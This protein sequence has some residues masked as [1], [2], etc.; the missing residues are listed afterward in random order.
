M[1]QENKVATIFGIIFFSPYVVFAYRCNKYFL[2]KEPLTGGRL[3][4]RQFGWSFLTAIPLVGLIYG[5]VKLDDIL[6]TRARIR[7]L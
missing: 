6:E 7:A 4:W 3:F 5:L 2:E 1:K